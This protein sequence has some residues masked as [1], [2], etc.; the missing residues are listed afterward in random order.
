MLNCM[1]TSGQSSGISEE[2]FEL[3]VVIFNIRFQFY[4]I[5]FLYYSVLDSWLS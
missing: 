1:S 2:N 5:N 4:I 3:H